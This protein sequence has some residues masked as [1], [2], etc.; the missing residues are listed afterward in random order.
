MGKIYFEIDTVLSE[1]FKIVTQTFTYK[2]K[3]WFDRKLV[4]NQLR[5]I[6]ELWALLDLPIISYVYDKN[7]YIVNYKY[8][9]C[10]PIFFKER[11]GLYFFRYVRRYKSCRNCIGFDNKR[12]FCDW[13]QE[14]IFKEAVS[15]DGFLEI[16]NDSIKKESR[17]H[18]KT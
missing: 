8:N 2:N 6:V 10:R 3:L 16:N 7:K 5:K 14:I 15:C 1:D 11:D 18:K 17:I 9:E 13:K 4:T 12:R